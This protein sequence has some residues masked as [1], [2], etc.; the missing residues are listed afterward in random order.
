MGIEVEGEIVREIE[1]DN[2]TIIDR[3]L[4]LPKLFS[5]RRVT[6]GFSLKSLRSA[7]VEECGALGLENGATVASFA[8]LDTGQHIHIFGERDIAL[9]L[10]ELPE[11]S[12]VKA[13]AN[14]AFGTFKQVQWSD[15]GP[16]PEVRA[17][18]GLVVTQ[19][20]NVE[21]PKG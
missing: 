15:D 4:M 11:K 21:K 3:F 7:F 14:T 17:E 1:A 13:I 2:D 12:H 8:V 18:T 10:H 19:I 9:V 20:L 5:G 16:V 6:I